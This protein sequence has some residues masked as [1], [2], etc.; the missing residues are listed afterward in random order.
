MEPALSW[1]FCTSLFFRLDISLRKASFGLVKLFEFNTRSI[2]RF[3]SPNNY[4]RYNEGNGQLEF[5]R[6]AKFLD[7]HS[8]IVIIMAETKNIKQRPRG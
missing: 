2:V 4:F 8:R 5:H 1:L 6:V 3:S 7:R